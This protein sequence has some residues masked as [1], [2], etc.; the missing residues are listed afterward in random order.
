M[1]FDMF[2][3]AEPGY[4][5]LLIVIPI[6][7][8]W[9]F[10]MRKSG[11]SVLYADASSWMGAP[12]VRT[13]LDRF[14]RALPYVALAIAIVALARP[15]SGTREVDVRSESTRPFFGR[16]P[17][18]SGSPRNWAPRSFGS[19]ERTSSR[20]SRSSRRAKGSRMRCLVEAAVQN[21]GSVC[22]AR[23]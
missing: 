10:R 13:W 2:R 19:R 8:V 3:F 5:L 15:Q 12:T 22:S 14:V 21:G 18:T 17:R 4:L 16:S 6:V 7:L 11:A 20:R 9:Q 1:S 23:S